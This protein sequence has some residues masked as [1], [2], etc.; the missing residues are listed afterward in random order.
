MQ[1]TAQAVGQ[2]W[3]MSK[4]RRGGRKFVQANHPQLISKLLDPLM[5]ISSLGWKSMLNSFAPAWTVNPHIP[6][7]SRPK[8]PGLDEK[9]KPNY[10]ITKLSNYSMIHC[11]AVC[12]HLRAKF[13]YRGRPPRRTG[14]AGVPR[15]HF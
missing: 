11:H 5:H 10:L 2:P 12:L 13:S 1:P 9:M 14:T 6:L 15:R 4:P 8:P 7:H 3:K